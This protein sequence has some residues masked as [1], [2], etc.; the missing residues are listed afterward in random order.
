MDALPTGM[1][2]QQTTLIQGQTGKVLELTGF[3]AEITLWP[4]AL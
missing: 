1:L 3:V 2:S 4:F